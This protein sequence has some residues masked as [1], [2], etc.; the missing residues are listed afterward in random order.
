MICTCTWNSPGIPLTLGQ[1]TMTKRTQSL[2]HQLRNNA[3]SVPSFKARLAHLVTRCTRRCADNPSHLSG[4]GLFLFPVQYSVNNQQLMWAFRHFLQQ[5][6]AHQCPKDDLTPGAESQK[7]TY[8]VRTKRS[9]ISEAGS[10]FFLI[11]CQ[12]QRDESTNYFPK[13]DLTSCCDCLRGF[14]GDEYSLTIAIEG[15]SLCRKFSAD[16]WV[17][18]LRSHP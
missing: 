15:R 7:D 3:V 6:T 1:N 5:S 9:N 16:I 8:I 18:L 2:I 11:R 4:L 14:T 13:H 17:S 10:W 12:K